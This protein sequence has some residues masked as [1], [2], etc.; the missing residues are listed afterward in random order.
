MTVTVPAAKR[1]HDRPEP[2][3]QVVSG[4]PGRGRDSAPRAALRHAK[5]VAVRYLEP[6]AV[7]LLVLAVL[8]GLSQAGVIRESLLPPVTSVASALATE[9]AE[10][11]L[12]T[13]VVD[14]MRGWAI[15][16]GITVVTAVPLGIAIGS[17]RVVYGLTRLTVDVLRPIPTVA[18]LPLLILL[19]GTGTKMHVA[20]VVLTAF[21]PLL[22][23]TIY[24]V[25]DVD[26]V[27]RDTARVYRLSRLRQLR[28]VVIPSALPYIAT[29]LRIAAIIALIVAIAASLIAGGSG[30]GAHIGNA[31]GAGAI[32]LMYGLIFVAGLLGLLVTAFFTQL[33]RYTLHWHQ[34]QR[35]GRPA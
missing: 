19:Y 14:S 18:F 16:L 24:G 7:V 15:G 23:Q 31:A 2:H 11:E 33:E 34:S 4:R 3:H 29:G 26:P 1:G 17:S 13:N 5:R 10:G 12:W 9:A 20:L 25:R 27:A 35:I 28:A 30:L 6:A 21:W 32:A 8:E 22:V